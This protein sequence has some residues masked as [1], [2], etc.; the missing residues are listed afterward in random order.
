[1]EKK[2]EQVFGEEEDVFSY[3]KQPNAPM[4]MVASQEM[5]RNGLLG[6][7][8]LVLCILVKI[9]THLP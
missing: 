4:P 3:G 8:V 9:K 6:H 7:L 2:K 1:M 5:L